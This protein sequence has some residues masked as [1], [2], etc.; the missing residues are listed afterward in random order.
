MMAS[1]QKLYIGLNWN[2]IPKILA[3]PWICWEYLTV[4]RLIRAV[5]PNSWSMGKL[6]PGHFWSTTGLSWPEWALNQ[7]LYWEPVGQNDGP[8]SENGGFIHPIHG[9][10]MGRMLSL[11]TKPSQRVAR[12]SKVHNCA[13]WLLETTLQQLERWTFKNTI[14]PMFMEDISCIYSILI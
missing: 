7:S 10:R 6:L 1:N 2:W 11:P 12:S 5:T 4:K 14:F 13:S 8:L 9:Q 3:K